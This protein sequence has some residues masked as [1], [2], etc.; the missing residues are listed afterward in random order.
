MAKI[1]MVI[2]SVGVALINYQRAVVLKEK[3]GERHLPIWVDG[4]QADAITTGLQEASS[5]KLLT[6]DFICFILSY[7]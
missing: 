1:E 7:L 5:S 4:A 2:E 3:N 6:H